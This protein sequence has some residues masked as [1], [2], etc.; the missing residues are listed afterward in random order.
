MMS[1]PHIVDRSRTGGF[2]VELREE[3]DIGS[4]ETW[5][6]GSCTEQLLHW[7]NLALSTH[8]EWP[9]IVEDKEVPLMGWVF[10]I[11]KDNEIVGQFFKTKA[12]TDRPFYNRK[13]YQNANPDSV[14]SF[15]GI[16]L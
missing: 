10:R 8:K 1:Y 15:R 6:K 13:V 7:V 14:V 4:W 11:R 16:N 2:S 5:Y 9:L 12:Q 3:A